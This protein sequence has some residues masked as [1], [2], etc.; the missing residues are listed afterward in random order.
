M[1][2]RHRHACW[3][4]AECVSTNMADYLRLFCTVWVNCMSLSLPRH[5]RLTHLQLPAALVL[6]AHDLA[7]RLLRSVLCIEGLLA[8]VCSRAQGGAP[9]S[10]RQVD[11]PGVFCTLQNYGFSR[12]TW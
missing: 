7:L 9:A 1:G 2:E 8:V 4:I 5:C 11:R 6:R 12:R 3:A 10:V